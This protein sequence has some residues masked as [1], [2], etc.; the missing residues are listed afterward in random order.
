MNIKLNKEISID[1]Q[2]LMDSRML[3]Q[4]NSGGGKSWAIRR[5]LEQ[6]HGKV[7]QI[8]IDLE[9][10]FQTLREKFDYIVAGRG[11]D[12]EISVKT[13]ELLAK[14]ILE[15]EVSA[16]I[17]L[18]EMH[19]HE[20]KPFV[21]IFLESLLRARNPNVANTPCFVVIDEAH[22]FAPEKDKSE[23]ASAVID[24]CTRGR[25]RALCAILATQRISKLAKDAAAE[26]NNKLIGR[27]GQDIDMKRASDELGFTTKEQFAS[28]RKLEPGEFYVFGTAISQEVIK[29]RIG[30]V[31]TV[32]QVRKGERRIFK[33]VPPTDKIKGILSKLA[34]LPQEAKKEADTISSLR[35]ETVKLKKLLAMKN[36]T[37]V[38]KK[39]IDQG[40]ID[41]AVAKAR[42]ELGREHVKQQRN[43]LKI[44][45]Q[46][47]K[48]IQPTIDD[49]LPLWNAMPENAIVGVDY[50]KPGGD[51]TVAVIAKKEPT[52]EMRIESSF[53]ITGP[54]QKILNAI[55]FLNAMGVDEPNQTAVAFIAGYAYGGGGFNN[56]RGSLRTKGLVEYR[57]DKIVLT[58]E[59]QTVAITPI[60]Q[61][62]QEEVHSMALSILPNPEKRLLE[63][64]ISAYPNAMTNEDLASASGYAPGSGGFNNPKG[65]L[66]SLGL[67]EYPAPGQVIASKILFP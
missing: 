26:C 40:A 62:T 3:I 61:P 2:K 44:F 15:L 5:L 35:E 16:I 1:L 48:L 11:G 66:R 4:A 18:S 33:A 19:A 46:I 6:S 32:H 7:Q 43:F 20:R 25:K 29:T 41:N 52:G 64:L 10:E 37:F 57:G 51:K 14:K 23:A 36:G 30:E 55:A 13:A 65:R 54:E 59:G 28:I 27:A 58:P 45:E 53:E 49:G 38:E 12:V 34:D 60:T 63:P 22:H 8:V 39:V 50:A 42:N 31:Q 67:V 21:R 9:G 47:R 17:D 56:P 24:L